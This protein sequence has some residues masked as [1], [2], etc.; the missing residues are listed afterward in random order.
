MEGEDGCAWHFGGSGRIVC[1]FANLFV[2][3]IS[4]EC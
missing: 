4:G 2:V 3:V 1:L